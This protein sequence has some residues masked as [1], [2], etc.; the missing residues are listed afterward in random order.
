MRIRPCADSGLLVE[1]DTLDD[2]IALHSALL[3]DTPPGVTEI[4]PAARTILLRVD[5]QR[6]SVH[7]VAATVRELRPLAGRRETAGEVRVPVTYDGPDL[8]EVSR[9][10]GLTVPEVVAA[11]TGSVW[12]VA[13]CGFA[14][15]FGYLVT[16][17]HDRLRV[18]RRSESRLRVPAGAV[19]LAGEFSGIYPTASPGGWQLIGRTDTVIWD[20]ERDP[21]GLLRP[22]T[23]VRFVD[24]RS[25]A[26]PGPDT[27]HEGEVA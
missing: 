18:P 10:T 22:G 4:V 27:C 1:V 5:P 14:P 17:E 23:R 12:T 21:P 6:R 2:V 15:G 26:A 9:L 24:V 11:H 7:D 20:L 13:F 8:T 3:E 25:A 16:A 19:G